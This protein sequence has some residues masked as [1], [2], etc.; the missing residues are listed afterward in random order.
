ML[1][2]DG[3]VVCE[4]EDEKVNIDKY[5]VYRTKKYGSKTVTVFDTK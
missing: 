3:I 5:N 2:S 4:Y 1:T